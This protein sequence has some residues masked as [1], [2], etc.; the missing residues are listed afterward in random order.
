MAIS[1]AHIRNTVTAY[2][3]AHPEDKAHLDVVLGLLDGGADLTSRAE[4]LGH[5]TAGAILADLDGQV[6]HIHHNALNRWL[7]P[8]GHLEDVDDD[9]AGAALRELVEEAGLDGGAVALAE[10]RPVHIDVHPIPANPAK[11]EGAHLHV[12]FRYLFRLERDAPV[13]LQ[14]EEVSGY[15]WKTPDTIADDTLRDRVLRLI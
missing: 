1:R 15:A 2:L 6:L 8:G 11:G 5:V 7:L 9:L 3:D 14:A 10:P 4:M 13:T 12:D